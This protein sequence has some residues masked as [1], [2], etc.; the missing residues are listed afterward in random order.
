MKQ[1]DKYQYN[2]KDLLGM[3]ST[4]T[5]VKAID[6][7]KNQYALRIIKKNSITDDEGLLCA[8]LDEIRLMQ[9]LKHPKIVQLVEVIQTDNN[10]YV[11]MEL[12]KQDLQSHL[13]Q[14]HKMPESECIKL[15]IDLLEGFT[16]LINH[17][18]V[19]RGLKL[20]NIMLTD[21][22]YKLA[23]CGLTKCL[24]N[25]K[26]EQSHKDEDFKFHSPQVLLNS[27]YTNK[28][29]IWS[30]GMILYNALYGYTAWSG[31]R[32]EQLLHNIEH[33]LL[34]FPDDQTSVSD[35][36]KQFIEGCLT[37]EE[38]ERM[39]WDEV[40]KHRL[41]KDYFKNYKAHIKEEQIKFLMNE[42]RQKI[43]KQNLNIS[44][45]FQEFDENGD[46]TLQFSELVQLLHTIDKTLSRQDCQ[47]IFKKL[48]LDGD[49]S[50]SLEEFEKWI[51]DNNTKMAVVSKVKGRQNQRN[52]VSKK[53]PSLTNIQNNPGKQK[54]MDF[55]GIQAPYQPTLGQSQSTPFI[56]Q[57]PIQTQVF[58]PERLIEKL[59]L[60]IQRYNINVHDLFQKFDCDFDGLL[61]FQEFAQ[62]LIKIQRNVQPQELQAVFRIFDL[63]DDNFISF[64]EFRQILNLYQ[65]K[66]Q[67]QESKFFS[68]GYQIPQYNNQVSPFQQM[69][70][71][72][73]QTYQAKTPT[74]TDLL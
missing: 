63:N 29:D 15:L 27:K 48:D 5:V 31:S 49:Q 74:Y 4:G 54:D 34:D 61:S 26:K 60:T 42:L 56:N 9:Q 2:P 7:K 47:V 6:N 20:T 18:I 55:R 14:V 66:S 70:T 51:T 40:F 50:V 28:C 21:K 36:M 19:H 64:I 25:F 12:C 46:K 65:E 37:M 59:Q 8:L 11:V 67:K 24:E 16:E 30:I 23:D 38:A 13:Q 71:M 58:D 53:M 68:S 17:G 52:S 69:G 22:G 39:N 43:I 44:S 33:K 73:Y 35:D 45:L 41:V 72:P 10:Y 3:G 1:I 62:V 57:M 32:I